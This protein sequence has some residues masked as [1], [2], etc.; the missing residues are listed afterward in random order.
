MPVLTVK[1]S[2]AHPSSVLMPSP[3]S[4][5]DKTGHLLSLSG[6]APLLPSGTSRAH[7]DRVQDNYLPLPCLPSNTLRSRCDCPWTTISTEI[8]TFAAVDIGAPGL[9]PA[10]HQCPTLILNGF[11]GIPGT[12]LSLQDPV[13]QPSPGQDLQ[14]QLQSFFPSHLHC[15]HTLSSFFLSQFNLIFL[16]QGKQS[17]S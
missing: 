2:T 9:V 10:G 14:S 6:V 7:R 16:L 13:L 3:Y 17:C 12:F 15:R 1:A 8:V 4:F 5:S 11:L